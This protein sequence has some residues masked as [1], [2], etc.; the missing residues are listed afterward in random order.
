MRQEHGV[1]A[2]RSVTGHGEQVRRVNGG[3]H[4]DPGRRTHPGTNA[5]SMHPGI[6]MRG[7][8][9]FVRDRASGRHR[10]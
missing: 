2:E 7:M 5:G 10:Q 1:R 6:V 9:E 3:H 8:L 4:M